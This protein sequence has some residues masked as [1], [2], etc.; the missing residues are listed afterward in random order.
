MRETSQL[1]TVQ[2]I[3]RAESHAAVREAW[4]AS[5]FPQLGS[6]RAGIEVTTEQADAFEAQFDQT[7]TRT[8][9]RL[10]V[11]YFIT[12]GPRTNDPADVRQSFRV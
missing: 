9:I 2:L 11:T 12:A 8:P 1:I 5:E 4:K 3:D 10:T 7:V 6:H